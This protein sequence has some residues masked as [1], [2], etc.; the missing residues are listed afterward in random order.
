[1]TIKDQ[2]KLK[3][4]L[5]ERFRRDVRTLFNRIRYEFRIKIAA[6]N[7]INP[8]K[9]EKQWEVLLLGHT[10]RVQKAFRPIAT[11]KENDNEEVAAALLLWAEV[12][13]ARDAVW[14]TN[15]T[16][17]EMNEAIA[18][19]RRTFADDGT[20]SYTTRELAAVSGA[21]LSRKFKA[22]E[23]TIIITETQKAAESTKLIVAYDEAELSPRDALAPTMVASQA[24]KDWYDVGDG[25]VRGGHH[26]W[27]VKPVPIT[28]PYIVNGQRLM[29]PGDTSMG[30]SLKNT[31]NCRCTSTYTF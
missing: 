5:E 9:F 15:T 1:M 31:A 17:N 19:A 21:I 7:I 13:S 4:K 12:N 11:V 6:N 25:K 24:M 10:T 2:V 30:A 20:I 23:T 22:R 8:L 28:M 27:E 26:K 16:R 14:I 29:Y 18:Q 3:I